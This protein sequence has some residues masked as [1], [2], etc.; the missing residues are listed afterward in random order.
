MIGGLLFQMRRA[1]QS[2][3]GNKSTTEQLASE[4]TALQSRE[5]KA[6]E[7]FW[8]KEKLAQECGRALEALWDSLNAA[9]NKFDIVGSFPFG[10]LVVGSPSLRLALPHFTELFDLS[11][12]ARPWSP[13]GF[14]AFLAK[15]RINGWHLAQTEFRHNRF[16]T[17]AQ[18]RP[19]HSTF[20]F[21]AH[22]TNSLHARRAALEGNLKIEWGTAASATGTSTVA[23]RIDA[24]ELTLKTHNGE[25]AFREVLLE[26]I[27]PPERSYFI[28]P[29]IVYDLDGDGS[30]E[31]ILAAKNLILRRGP[32]DQFHSEALCAHAPGLIFT[33]VIADFDR[34][35]ISDFLCAKFEGLML[36]KGTAAGKFDQPGQL[37][38]AAQPRL[39]YAQVL[40]CGDIDGDND[41]DVWLGQYKGPYERGQMPTPYYDANDGHPGYLLVN[42]GQGSFSDATVAAGLDR[43]RWRRS[44]SASF[45][46]LDHDGDLDLLVVSDFAGLDLF[47][48]NGHGQFSDTSEQWV[49]ERHGFGMAHAMAD[50]NRDG[51]LDLLM[52][53]MNSPTADRLESLRADRSDRTD[54]GQM[55][56]RMAFGNRLYQGHA[57]QPF[58]RQSPL[59]DTIARA[60]WA[61][62]CTAFDFDN[63]GFVDVYVAN[64]HESKQS[65]KDYEPEFWL[66]DIYVGD[67]KE[68]IVATAYFGSKIEQTRARDYSYGGYE[69]NRLYYNHRGESFVEI[70]HLMGV[71]FEQ[72][73]RNVVSED[74]DGDGRVDLVV[75]TFEVFPQRQQTVRILKNVIP[76]CGNWIGFRIRDTGGRVSSVAARVT[77]HDGNGVQIKQVTTGDSYRSQHSGTIHF[78]LGR[79]TKVTRV[80]IQW[81]DRRAMV[82]HRPEINRYH[83]VVRPAGAPTP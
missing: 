19:A 73:S 67:S 37:V 14:R 52:I 12:E 68:N 35:G 64:G 30:S 62:G 57:G 34:D 44:Y 54:Y 75:T 9:S 41:L 45:A 16:A 80:E 50:F 69:K 51:Q 27:D 71:G 76:D 23:R 13:E 56:S 58:F 11:K 4:L 20:Y 7:T 70:G 65:V 61:W 22:L 24:R 18:G 48:N 43:K 29:L 5:R 26:R 63:D 60:G 8:A 38:W 40:T 78:G 83:T 31:I 66:H 25:P 39:R 47:A 81:P 28:D 36:F 82:L 1:K 79:G 2:K 77:L 59:N 10:D 53:G 6:A 33:G 3:P 21:A 55:R 32:G 17:D 49:T 74:L 15:E 42:D 46:D 72:D